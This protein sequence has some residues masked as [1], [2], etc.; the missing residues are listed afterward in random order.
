M[1]R[2]L[3]LRDLALR[4]QAVLPEVGGLP[5]PTPADTT[6]S[7]A[8]DRLRAH[9]RAT[10]G[11]H[12]Q[13]DELYYSLAL[14]DLARVA[15]QLDELVGAGPS[16]PWL[17]LF[18]YI[19]AAPRRPA[20]SG[21]P[22]RSPTEQTRALMDAAPKLAGTADPV[23]ELVAAGWIA[24]DPFTGHRRR[25]LHLHLAHLLES[26]IGRWPRDTEPLYEAAGEHRHQAGLWD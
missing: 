9:V 6:W 25:S 10:Q 26:L 11:E 4:D 14:G 17:E 1:L 13:A 18:Q 2:R 7:T 20:R 15:C 23:A 16:G 3:L 5:D 19:T 12:A 8:F 22:P 21:A 24:A